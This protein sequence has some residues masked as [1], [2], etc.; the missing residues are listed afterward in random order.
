MSVW[1]KEREEENEGD[2]AKAIEE[3]PSSDVDGDR[4]G[5]GRVVELDETSLEN[6]EI[7]PANDTSIPINDA[8]VPA[9]DVSI[10]GNYAPSTA[11]DASIPVDD[12]S[13]PANNE[14]AG[15]VEPIDVESRSTDI[16]EMLHSGEAAQQHD[17]RVSERPSA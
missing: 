5:S 2:A 17:E 11:K 16:S 4:S 7:S 9:N 3:K 8:S 15:R 6:D 12:G 1:E 10:P 13:S 14:G